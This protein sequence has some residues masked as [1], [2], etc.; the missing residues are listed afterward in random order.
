MRLKPDDQSCFEK[1]Y[2]YVS[3]LEGLEL[4]RTDSGTV[5]TGR[6]RLKETY[7]EEGCRLLKT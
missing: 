3:Q 1:S 5:K 6:V 7:S 2:V 4:E